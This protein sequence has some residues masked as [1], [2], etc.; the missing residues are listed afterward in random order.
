MA[1]T[2]FISYGGPDEDLARKVRDSLER[3]GVRTWFF[4]ED[5]IPGDKLHRAMWRGVNEHDYVLALCSKSALSRPGFLNELERVLER[6]AKEGGV[7]RLIPVSLDDALWSEQW[8]PNGREDLKEQ[9]LSRV[10]CRLPEKIYGS[11]FETAIEKI[12][13]AVHVQP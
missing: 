3:C 11:E 5:A 7:A 9:I 1:D 6:E 10:V 2:V 13:R 12:V 8:A 4:P